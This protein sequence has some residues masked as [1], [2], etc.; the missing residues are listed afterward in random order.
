MSLN[1]SWIKGPSK[2]KYSLSK[3]Q[4]KPKEKGLILNSVM[5]ILGK[6]QCTLL[7]HSFSVQKA[8]KHS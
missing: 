3:Q 2:V 8:N 7:Q 6:S 4:Q 5:L 1:T